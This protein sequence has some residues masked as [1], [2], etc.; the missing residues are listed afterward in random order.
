[1]I[2]KAN[3]LKGDNKITVSPRLLSIATKKLVVYFDN[4]WDPIVTI[5]SLKLYRKGNLY[6]ID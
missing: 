6:F 4:S 2:G 5:T 1:M 3:S